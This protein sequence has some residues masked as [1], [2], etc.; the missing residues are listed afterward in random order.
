MQPFQSL[1]HKSYQGRTTAAA[2]CGGCQ[3][4]NWAVL[5]LCR[6]QQQGLW[7]WQRRENTSNLSSKTSIGF[8]WRIMLSTRVFHWRTTASVAQPHNIS[9]SCIPHYE[10]PQS[11][12]LASQS[13][14]LIPSVVENHTKKKNSLATGLCISNSA[15]RLLNALPQVLRET[16]SSSACLCI[17]TVIGNQVLR[18]S[19]SSKPSG[20]RLWNALP[21]VQRES[22]SSPVFHRKLQIHLFLNQWLHYHPS[23]HL[24]LS[25][26]IFFYHVAKRMPQYVPQAWLFQV[27]LGALQTDSHHYHH[28]HQQL[29]K[30]KKTAAG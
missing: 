4:G 5:N 7:H 16:V 9:K 2:V 28:H 3:V 29:L 27:C 19:V 15:S 6:T 13:C 23:L 12:W 22:V 24:F 20:P 11:L 25:V 14:L 17:L 8:L 18:E 10:P 30:T 1:L 26:W 21:Q